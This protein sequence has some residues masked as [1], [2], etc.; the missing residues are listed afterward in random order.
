M[1]QVGLMEARPPYVTFQNIEVEDRD[2]SI[3]N[4]YYTPKNVPHAVITPCGGRD[5]VTKPADEWLKALK[6]DGM[7]GRTPLA[8]HDHF[9]VAFENWKEGNEIPEYGTPVLTF[10]PF[11]PAQR[12]AL[13]NANI[14]TVEDCAEMAEDTMQRVGMGARELRDRAKAALSSANKLEAE[15]A[16]LKAKLDMQG[17]ELEA[18][19]DQVKLLSAKQDKA[20]K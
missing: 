11:T 4:G 10:L 5:S 8:W 15:N 9:K 13:I 20:S 19:R 1:A 16:A 3:E 7:E 2:A 12:Q 14:R 18:L 6:K 17:E